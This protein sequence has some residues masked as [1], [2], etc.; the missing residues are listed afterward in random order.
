MLVAVRGFFLS[1]GWSQDTQKCVCVCV[2]VHVI[3]IFTPYFCLL[4]N[5]WADTVSFHVN[6]ASPRLCW[7][8]PWFSISGPSLSA[9]AF[10]SLGSVAPGS[11]SFPWGTFL[12]CWGSG[13]LSWVFPTQTGLRHGA[14]RCPTC[15]CPLCPPWALARGSGPRGFWC[16]RQCRPLPPSAHWIASGLTAFQKGENKG[17]AR[18]L[19]H[20][21]RSWNDVLFFI[22]DIN[23]LCHLFFFL[24]SLF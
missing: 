23:N 16:H 13:S 1:P 4:L 8:F 24:T 22:L 6:P 15:G 14:W 7:F 18:R 12:P 9:D 19:F 10:L 11:A 5:T 20:V 17:K 21:S 2:C 3:C